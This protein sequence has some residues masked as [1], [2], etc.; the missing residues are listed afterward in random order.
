MHY[1]KL[2]VKQFSKTTK[3]PGSSNIS[4]VRSGLKPV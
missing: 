4:Y 2:F 1:L 3:I